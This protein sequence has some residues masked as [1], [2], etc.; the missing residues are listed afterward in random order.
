MIAMETSD[1][2][3]SRSLSTPHDV[4]SVDERGD[5]I[6]FTAS[7]KCGIHKGSSEGSSTTGIE[8]P[9]DIHPFAIFDKNGT[10][11]NEEV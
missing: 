9:S 7:L 2:K 5:R 1:M 3:H 10:Q 8:L 11:N 4:A 6:A